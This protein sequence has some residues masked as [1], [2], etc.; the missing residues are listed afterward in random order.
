MS[1]KAIGISVVDATG[2]AYSSSTQVIGNYTSRNGTDLY[3][4]GVRQNTCWQQNVFDT[5]SPLILRG[6]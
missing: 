3:W 6:C 1:N 4:D 2:R 5:A